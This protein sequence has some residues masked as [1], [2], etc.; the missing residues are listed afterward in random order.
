[1]SYIFTLIISALLQYH[2]VLA[3]VNNYKKNLTPAARSGLRKKRILAVQERFYPPFSCQL[4]PTKRPVAKRVFGVYLV[5]GHGFLTKG[6]M[7]FF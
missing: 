3:Q 6:P 7:F 2:I 4:V 1:M 5:Q